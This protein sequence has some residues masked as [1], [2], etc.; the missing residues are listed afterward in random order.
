MT[1]FI[2]GL[3]N[4][5]LPGV[6]SYV[7]KDRVSPSIGMTRIFHCTGSS[8]KSLVK[9]DGSYRLAPHN[10]R[11]DIALYAIRGVAYNVSF[12]W[13]DNGYPGPNYQ[14]DFSSE[15]VDGNIGASVSSTGTLTISDIAPI[16][17]AGL[18]L[19][20]SQI[21]TVIAPAG[22]AWL[23]QEGPMAPTGHVSRCYSINPN[24][25]LQRSGMYLPMDDL[26]LE[27]AFNDIFS[28]MVG[29]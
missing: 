3:K 5:H 2:S 27:D 25:D 29:A 22:S 24:L 18:F 28:G 12:D 1:H 17:E 10:H 11:Q 21:H 4:C 13:E 9:E 14:W 6:N 7:L 26:E 23:V 19:P 16:T 8:M 20:S 15:I